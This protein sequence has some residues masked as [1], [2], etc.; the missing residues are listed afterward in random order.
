MFTLASGAEK[1]VATALA[2]VVPVDLK[3]RR[4]SSATAMPVPTIRVPCRRQFRFVFC[5]S[6]FEFVFV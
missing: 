2:T 6:L 3:G 4:C 5:S 1:L